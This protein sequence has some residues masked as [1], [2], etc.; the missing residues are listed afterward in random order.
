MDKRPLRELLRKRKNTLFRKGH[1]TSFIHEVNVLILV[2]KNNKLD[3]YGNM[4]NPAGLL[5]DEYK[6][7]RSLASATSRFADSFRWGKQ[8]P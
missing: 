8:S 4:D 1:E 3:I 7:I 6:V 2:N 5:S